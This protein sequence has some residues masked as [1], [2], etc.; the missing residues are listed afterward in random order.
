MGPCDV[1][2][3]QY[4]D[5]AKPKSNLIYFKFTFN[6]LLICSFRLADISDIV[7]CHDLCMHFMHCHLLLIIRQTDCLHKKPMKKQEMM[8]IIRTWKTRH[9]GLRFSFR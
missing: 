5:L 4:I 6:I 9:L 1:I 7:K 8:S 2:I 3:I